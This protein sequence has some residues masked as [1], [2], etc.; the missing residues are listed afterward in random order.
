VTLFLD[1]SVLL[2]ACGSSKGASRELFRL[3]LKEEWR[4][5]T[6]P[7]ALEEVEQNLKNLRRRASA[8][9]CHRAGNS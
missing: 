2:A 9:W 1:T 8:D 7:Y 6:I 5:V 4:L 3:A